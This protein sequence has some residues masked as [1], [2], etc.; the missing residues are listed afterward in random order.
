M[1]NKANIYQLRKKKIL[2]LFNNLRGIKVFQYLYKKK[3]FLNKKY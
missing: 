1:L 2:Y 3:K